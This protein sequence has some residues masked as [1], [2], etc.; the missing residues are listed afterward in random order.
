MISKSESEQ[1]SPREPLQRYKH[2]ASMLTYQVS[3]YNNHIHTN[4]G[5]LCSYTRSV[6]I[7]TTE[8]QTWGQLNF[9][10]KLYF[11]S[12]LR[13]SF[14]SYVFHSVNTR[15][16]PPPLMF[17]GQLGLEETRNIRCSQVHSGRYVSVYMEHSGFLTLC[18][19]Q[20][21]GSMS[22]GKK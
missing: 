3:Y 14:T 4:M 5:P 2:G 10:Y 1:T 20:V 8:I 6:T 13:L 16:C 9:Y 19:V 21:F 7:A 17:A 12:H 15:F 22:S 11:P 18:E